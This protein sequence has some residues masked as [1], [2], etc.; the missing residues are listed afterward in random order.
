[1]W[2]FEVHDS[3]RLGFRLNLRRGFAGVSMGYDDATNGESFL[4]LG[5]SIESALD[6]P[7][8]QGLAFSLIRAK[9]EE[10]TSGLCLVKQT[11]D[12]A[13][14]ERKALVLVDGCL[15]RDVG[16]TYIAEAYGKPTPELV[17]YTQGRGWVRKLYV[18]KPGDALFISWPAK[19][20]GTQHPKRFV[21][22][23][24]GSDLVE[25]PV[26]RPRRNSRPPKKVR[27]QMRQQRPPRPQ[28]LQT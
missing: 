22:T 11:E 2:L 7:D 20:L 8:D 17:T 12:E 24:D 16:I 13:R 4:P 9:L 26:G 1:M 10:K 15:D 5:N 27:E 19:A 14:D 6:H 25:T 18:F 23:W 21:I 3:P 28:E